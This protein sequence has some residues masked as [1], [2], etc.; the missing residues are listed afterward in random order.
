[1]SA[2]SFAIFTVIL[3]C[4]YISLHIHETLRFTIFEKTVVKWLNGQIP[5][6]SPILALVCRDPGNVTQKCEKTHIRYMGIYYRTKFQV[7]PL[8]TKSVSGRTAT[9]TKRK[10][11]QTITYTRPIKTH[12]L[13]TKQY[14]SDVCC[15]FSLH[16]AGISSQPSLS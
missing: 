9:Q 14:R 1:M 10:K 8:L 12:I 4:P 13:K 2:V 15:A 5:T 11:E 7:D 3:Y 6:L 16:E